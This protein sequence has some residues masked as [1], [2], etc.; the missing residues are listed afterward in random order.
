VRAVQP[1]LFGDVDREEAAARAAAAAREAERQPATCPAC[2]LTEP[3][4]WLLRN[5]H[6]PYPDGR[7]VAQVLVTNHIRYYV[8][9]NDAAALAERMQRGRELGLDVGAIVAAAEAAEATP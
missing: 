2:G 8:R 9:H 3:N 7:C 5:N 6:T 1:D 4:G